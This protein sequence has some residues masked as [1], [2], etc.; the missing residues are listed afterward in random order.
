[1]VPDA[2]IY[3]A[4]FCACETGVQPEMALEVFHAMQVQGVVP[5]N[6]TLTG[7][8]EK[9]TQCGQAVEMAQAMKWHGMVPEVIPYNVVTSACEKG[10]QPKQ[11]WRCSMQCSGTVLCVAYSLTAI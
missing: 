9:D 10:E 1:M 8:R 6:S 5:K 4:V 7:E 2:I 3:S 11:A